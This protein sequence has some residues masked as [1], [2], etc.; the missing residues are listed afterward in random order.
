M[1]TDTFHE[2]YNGVPLWTHF[3]EPERKFLVQG[4]RIISE[5]LLPFYNDK[6]EVNKSNET[7]WKVIERK[8]SMELGVESLS[9][10]WINTH[11]YPW[12]DV[13]KNFVLTQPPVT[14]EDEYM[15][16]R[17]S[18]FELAFRETR[19]NIEYRFSDVVYNYERIGQRDLNAFNKQWGARKTWALKGFDDSVHELNTRFRQAGIALSYHNG[20][21]QQ[22]G[23]QMIAATIEA[24]FWDLVSSPKWKNVETDMLEA[25]DRRDSQDRDP[26]LYASKALESTIKIISSEQGWTH[27]KEGG[28][29]NFLENLGKKTSKFID[30]WE[31]EQM[32]IY[33]THVRNP[34]GHGPGDEPM[35]QLTNSQT[36]WA[37]EFAMIWIK[38]LIS[39][40]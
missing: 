17:V 15:K 40:L 18:F 10:T 32:K 20:F 13:C 12:V 39:R 7:I 37:I 6:G 26:A 21:V 19:A 4:F 14:H 24:P 29:H 16:Q 34:L 36:N 9:A 33:F 22:S 38:S 31:M 11:K 23:D 5:Q 8:L 3:R 1:L 30:P 35:P 28:V 25:V 27:G 2:R